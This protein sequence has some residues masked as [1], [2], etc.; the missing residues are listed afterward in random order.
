M[1]SLLDGTK[2]TYI[3][4]QQGGKSELENEINFLRSM[5]RENESKEENLGLAYLYKTALRI[6]LARRKW[7]KNPNKSKKN[8][9]QNFRLGFREK[10]IMRIYC[11]SECWYSSPGNYACALHNVLA[12]IP[13][14]TGEILW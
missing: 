6:A 1:F 7:E 4:I 11:D 8:F 12:R 14:K 2:I 13:H 5:L 9:S 10:K 3:F